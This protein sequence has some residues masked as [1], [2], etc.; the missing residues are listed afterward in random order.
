MVHNAWLSMEAA[1]SGPI[2]LDYNA[3]TPI[4]PEVLDAMA[5]ALRELWG[6]PSSAHALGRRAA[7]AIEA[8]RAQV[9]ALLGAQ[10]DEI[11]FTSGG[12]ESDNAAIVGVAEARA[13]HGRHL[14]TSS[15]EHPA[16]EESCRYL[17]SRGWSVDRAPVGAD[18]RLIGDALGALIGD[19]TTLI[20]VMHANNE[21]GV[22]QPIE[23]ISRLAK[24][25][26]VAFHTDAAQSVGKIPVRVD[27]LG[28]DLLTL[29]GHKLYAPKGVGALYV[30]RGTPLKRFLHGA[31]HERGR[32]AG[33]ENTALIVGLGCA[34]RLA[35]DELEQRAAHDRTLRDRLREE[36]TARLPTLV[37]HGELSERLPNT[38]S[39][40][41][42]GIDAARLVEEL[43]G[44]AAAA[45]AACH[46]GVRQPS[47][48]LLAMGVDRATALATL[49][50]T[51]GRETTEVDVER[52]ANEIASRARSM[53]DCRAPNS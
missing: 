46:A 3:T 37:V 43:E 6:N 52:A 17:E 38:L 33:T 18:G 11:V 51:V 26:S 1:V 47:R 7:E 4:A 24:E 40:A 28:V 39:L 42:P 45:G 8:A 49:R 14:I 19:R 20:S 16:V 23:Q 53:I 31:G 50:L 5:P 27:E 10:D 21:T 13:S 41:I 48:V 34:C 25:C 9:A 22:V 2:Y 36:L 44:V 35:A 30:R 12:T 29:A 15:I 32:R